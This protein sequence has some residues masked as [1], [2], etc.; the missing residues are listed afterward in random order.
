MK[1]KG[2]T[3]TDRI[4]SIFYFVHDLFKNDR[5]TANWTATF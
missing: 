2:V 1:E 5:C 4:I 3:P